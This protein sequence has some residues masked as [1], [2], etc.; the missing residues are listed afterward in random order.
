MSG[1]LNKITEWNMTLDI[2]PLILLWTLF[3]SVQ[4]FY[5]QKYAVGKNVFI[6]SKSGFGI[7]FILN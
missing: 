1:L 2:M 6:S 5:I 4:S 7:Q 3:L